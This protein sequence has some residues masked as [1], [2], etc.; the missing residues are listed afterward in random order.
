MFILPALNIVGL[1]VKS[2]IVDSNPIL[3]LPP[4]ITNFILLS[5]SSITSFAE[6]GL[7]FEDIFAL[8]AA[9]GTFKILSKCLAI[10][11]FGILTATVFFPTV[12]FVEIFDFVFLCKIKVI[13][14]GQKAL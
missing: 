2:I 9:R 4:S 12:A 13:G 3:H 5:N 11:C 7:N 6:V 10:L 14:P 8:G 1:D